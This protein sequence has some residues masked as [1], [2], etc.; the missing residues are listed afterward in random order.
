[1]YLRSVDTFPPASWVILA[2]AIL[3][4]PIIS[5]SSVRISRFMWERNMLLDVLI[6][7]TLLITMVQSTVIEYPDASVCR[8]SLQI[9]VYSGDV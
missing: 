6:L 7:F 9:C 2:S 5:L 1:M 3:I 4:S 8:E